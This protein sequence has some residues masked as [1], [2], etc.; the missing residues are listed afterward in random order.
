MHQCW[1][2]FYDVIFY[3]QKEFFLQKTLTDVGEVLL[4][5]HLISIYTSLESTS[6]LHTNKSTFSFLVNSK[7][8]KLETSSTVILPAMASFPWFHHP[9]DC[10]RNLKS[11]LKCTFADGYGVMSSN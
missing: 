2:T 1:N 3:A 7:L 4:T 11:L 8:V 6:T 5:E 9:V 10:F